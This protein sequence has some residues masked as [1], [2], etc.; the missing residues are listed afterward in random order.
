[1]KEGKH[2]SLFALYTNRM[3]RGRVGGGSRSSPA[4]EPV[5]QI[6][7][8]CSTCFTLH[9]YDEA[10]ERGKITTREEKEDGIFLR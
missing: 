9:A 1:M 7:S 8:S 6:E 5:D 2:V 3:G 10:V 4:L